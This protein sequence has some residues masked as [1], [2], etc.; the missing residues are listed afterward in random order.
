[1]KK[2][3]QWEF[4]QLGEAFGAIKA[5]KD[6][7][8]N[9][10]F[11]IFEVQSW[12]D[13]LLEDQFAVLDVSRKATENF[14]LMIERFLSLY[15]EETQKPQVVKIRLQGVKNALKHFETIF[16]EELA[17]QDSYFVSKKGIYS[18]HDLI[19]RAE[20]AIEERIRSVMP[21]RAIQDFNQAGKCLAY[22]VATAAGYHVMRATEEMLREWHSLSV[23]N[24]RRDVP[25]G[26][27]IAALKKHNADATTLG[28]LDQ[29]RD[30]HRN[31]LMHPEHFLTVSEAHRLF[32]IAKSAITAIGEQIIAI[33]QANG[34]SAAANA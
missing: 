13:K 8:E 21:D 1:M 16:S 30:F 15:D 3:N 23:P 31:P 26:T 7:D 17:T 11:T 2:I 12:V 5:I 19:H 33:Q 25:W 20:R 6:D 10:M 14:K 4:Y 29:I 32:D 22:E 27:C 9:L 18:T 34:G 28:I 24:G